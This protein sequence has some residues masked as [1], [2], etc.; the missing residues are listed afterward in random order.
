MLERILVQWPSSRLV[1][2]LRR[3]AAQPGTLL[4]CVLSSSEFSV[5]FCDFVEAVY[6]SPPMKGFPEILCLYAKLFFVNY[7]THTARGTISDYSSICD[8]TSSIPIA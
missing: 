7:F 8:S 1:A 4:L 5:K 6:S 3:A 2:R